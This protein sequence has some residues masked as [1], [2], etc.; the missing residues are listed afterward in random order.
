MLPP[1]VCCSCPS[2]RAHAWPT[3]PCPCLQD[4]IASYERALQLE[5]GNKDLWL[6]L[7]MA[8]KELC[9]VGR[10]EEVRGGY[11]VWRRLGGE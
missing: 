1:S 11:W 5:P 9:I 2:R 8:C 4:G 10:A 7:G 3:L 6:N